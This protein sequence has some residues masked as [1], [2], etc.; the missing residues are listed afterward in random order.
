MPPFFSTRLDH[1]HGWC[2]DGD[3]ASRSLDTQHRLP[4]SEKIT[5]N[6]GHIDLG[7]ID[8]LVR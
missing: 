7:Q 8:L 2:E 5:V 3:M 4:E 1:P 6:L